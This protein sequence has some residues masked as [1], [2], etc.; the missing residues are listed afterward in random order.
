MSGIFNHARHVT[1][2]LALV[3][4][5]PL[6]IPYC[7]HR[8]IGGF[9]GPKTLQI[10]EFRALSSFGQNGVVQGPKTLQIGE[11]YGPKIL[12]IRTFSD[13]NT[14]LPDWRFSGIQSLKDIYAVFYMLLDNCKLWRR[15]VYKSACNIVTYT[16][17][18]L[19]ITHNKGC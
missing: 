11:F 8:Q 13:P 16:C 12:Q 14:Y 5:F 15:E 17:S 1:N 6:D 10:G 3:S 4:L 18:C 7:S 9:Q 19:V 2:Q